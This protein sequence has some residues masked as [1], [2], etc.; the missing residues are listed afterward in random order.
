MTNSRLWV[1]LAIGIALVPPAGT[2]R[3]QAPSIADAPKPIQELSSVVQGKRPDDIRTDILKRF[4]PAQR[5]TGSGYRIEHWDIAD[6]VLTFHPATG[7]IFVAQQTNKIFRLLRTKNLAKA[8]VLQSYEM[9]TLPDANNH[10]TRYWLGNVEFGRGKTYRFV[11]SGQHA[12]H[13]AEQTKNYFIQHPTGTVEVKYKAPVNADT[14]LES[15]PEATVVAYLVFTPAA[16]GEPATF[17]ITSSERAR[18][19]TFGA[20]K[21]LPFEMDAWWKSFWR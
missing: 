1:V 5:V 20:H 14:I 6:G 11:D 19:L 17:Y 12:N 13:R 3:A 16:N 7:P 15:L 8:N 9:T 2:A 18:R 4:G 21:P 10:S